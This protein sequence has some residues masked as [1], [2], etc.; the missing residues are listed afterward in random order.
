M[1]STIEFISHDVDPAGNVVNPSRVMVCGSGTL[2]QNGDRRGM[3]TV[4]HV[5]DKLRKFTDTGIVYFPAN[6]QWKRLRLKTQ[7]LAGVMFYTPPGSAVG[8]DSAFHL[9]APED[10]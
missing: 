10:A 4:G 3:V 1:L 8:P 2:V 6:A 5:V 9:L 7:D